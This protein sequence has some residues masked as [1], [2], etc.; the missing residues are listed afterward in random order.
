MDTFHFF[1]RL[2]FE[3]RARIWELTIEP[4]IV[5]VSVSQTYLWRGAPLPVTSTPVPAPLQT[6]QESR[7]E[8]QR[9]YERGFTGIDDPPH[10]LEPQQYVWVNFDMDIIDVGRYSHFDVYEK[11]ASMVQRLRFEAENHYDPVFDFGMERAKIFSNAKEIYVVCKYGLTPW[12]G[13][14]ED[15]YWPCGGENVWFIDPNDGTMMR[16]AELDEMV[17]KER[18]KRIIAEGYDPDTGLPIEYKAYASQKRQVFRLRSAL[19]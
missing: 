3:I 9:H 19:N 7:R 10:V 15:Y 2:P 17:E 13:A 5:D 8:L 12:W 16:G 1:P 6:C 14:L 18:R 11:V 4:R